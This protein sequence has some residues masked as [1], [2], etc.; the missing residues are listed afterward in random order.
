M[1]LIFFDGGADVLA[2]RLEDREQPQQTRFNE[3]NNQAIST[4]ILR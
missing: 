1:G 2:V 4:L 3:D